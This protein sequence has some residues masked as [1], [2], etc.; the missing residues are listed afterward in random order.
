[1]APA[2]SSASR[3]VD[4]AGG[5]RNAYLSD[6]AIEG[7]VRE[8]VDTDQVNGVG[9]ALSDSTVDGLYIRHTKVGLW[10]EP[11]TTRRCVP[12]RST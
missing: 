4:D 7:D 3:Y 11:R 10:F 2:A 12:G 8:R 1:M 9:G 5:S 6:F